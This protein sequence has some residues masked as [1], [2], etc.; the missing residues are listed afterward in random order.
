MNEQFDIL[1]PLVLA[2]EASTEQEKAFFELLENDASLQARYREAL[3]VWLAAS[4]RSFDA[5]KA[6]QTIK[7]PDAQTVSIARWWRTPAIAAAILVAL[8]AITAVWKRNLPDYA[9]GPAMLTVQSGNEIKEVRL[10]DGTVVWLNRHSQLQYPERF[11]DHER[12]VKLDGEAYFDVA[13][14]ERKRFVTETAVSETEVLGTEYNLHVANGADCELTV[15]EGKVSF[16]GK[17]EGN[18]LILE[19]G[20][21]AVLHQG[22]PNPQAL[23]TDINAT[24]WKTREMHFNA[25]PLDYMLRVMESVYG[26][27]YRLSAP[28]PG[29]R[30]RGSFSH[31]TEKEVRGILSESLGISFADSAGVTVVSPSHP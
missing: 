2:G 11:A 9:D 30:F 29:I 5:D 18:G 23:D 7:E 24:A 10:P 26:T 1:L 20:H 28:L 12:R 6:L 27:R 22:S 15:T 31:A 3:K 25:A 17:R 21:A 19:A 14:D 13:R 4:S 16:R 8:L